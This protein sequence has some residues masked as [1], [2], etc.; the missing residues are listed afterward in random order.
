VVERL[1]DHLVDDVLT[2][3]GAEVITMSEKPVMVVVTGN[4]MA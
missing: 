1:V 4:D 2:E 3:S